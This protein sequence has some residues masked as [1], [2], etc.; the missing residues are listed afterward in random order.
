MAA[1]LA[2]LAVL[3][4]DN[5]RSEDP[6]AIITEVQAGLKGP[7][8]L[9]VEEDRARAISTAVAVAAPGDV[10]VIAGKGHETGQDIGGHRHPFD[11]VEVA[12]EALRRLP[13]GGSEDRCPGGLAR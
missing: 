9:V 7:A 11:D 13:A 12:R 4:S 3:T 8:K 2:D 10:V 1:R 6:A 5:P